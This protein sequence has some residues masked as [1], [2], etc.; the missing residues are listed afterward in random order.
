MCFCI[1]IE[2]HVVDYHITCIFLFFFL[3][4]G[5]ESLVPYFSSVDHQYVPLTSS[6]DIIF[7]HWIGHMWKK[8]QKMLLIWVFQLNGKCYSNE[9]E[10]TNTLNL[11]DSLDPRNVSPIVHVKW[12]VEFSPASRPMVFMCGSGGVYFMKK[13]VNEKFSLW[14]WVSQQIS[15]VKFSY[16][17]IHSLTV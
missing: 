11:M 15:P 8:K 13:S 6:G 3:E 5:S 2:F 9:T 10:N 12:E 4:P 1:K 17:F 16:S 7:E 14:I